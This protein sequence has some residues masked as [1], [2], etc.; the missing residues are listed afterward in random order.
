M[1]GCNLMIKTI[2]AIHATDLKKILLFNIEF[3]N[4]CPYC[5]TGIEAKHL[6]TY[7]AE[8]NNVSSL[9]SLFFCP[10]CE[11]CFT[12]IYNTYLNQTTLKMLLPHNQNKTTFEDNLKNLSPEFVSIYNQAEI[13]EQNGLNHIC[14]LGYRK[15]LEFLVKDFSIHNNPDDADSI[16]SMPL[17]Q[18]IK[19]YITE[20]RIKTLAERSAWIGNDEAHYVRKQD[21][22]DISDMKKF[23]E[24]LVYFINM[25][26]VLEDA[27][28]MNPKK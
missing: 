23:I 10:K 1:K 7:I 14:G 27:A 26:S 13:A 2:H 9:Y 21:D 17:A 5:N 15:S 4:Q 8:Y 24:A 19:T 22:R 11:H 6:T 18:C 25:T 16:K 3:P 28:S 20:N 12:A